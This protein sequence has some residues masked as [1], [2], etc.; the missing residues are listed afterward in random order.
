MFKE[1]LQAQ[2]V[3]IYYY[4]KGSA[5]S[6]LDRDLIE[7]I[8]VASPQYL[9]LTGITPALSLINRQ[10]T[11]EA[12]AVAKTIG[13]QIVFDPNLRK[14]LWDI[15]E[16]LPVLLEIAHHADVIL[17][18][19]DE[20]AELTGQDEPE[21]IASAFDETG[22]KIVVVKRGADG[23]YYHAEAEQ[24]FVSAYKTEVVDEVGAGD[25]FAAGFLSGLLDGES[26]RGAVDRGCA[27]GAMAVAGVG[28]YENLPTRED[29]EL[30]M[31]GACR[32]KR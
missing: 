10:I 16:A 30:F 7:R 23:A 15:Q 18:G 11:F 25:A 26:L 27:L 5:A 32:I 14:K 9:F 12:I 17:V 29:L 24:G 19:Q 2:D 13:A 31:S 3:S 4:R 8:S 1:I 6:A 20:G 21:S 22:N 28:D